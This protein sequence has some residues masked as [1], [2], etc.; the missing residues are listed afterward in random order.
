MRILLCQDQVVDQEAVDLEAAH[1][2]AVASA[3]VAASGEAH[4][5]ADLEDPEAL[6]DLAPVDLVPD[7]HFLAVG[8]SDPVTT[9]AEVALADFWE[10]FW[11][12]L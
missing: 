3:A 12:Q 5:A 7:L 1:A 2:A 6:T 9:A 8:T 4:A 11:R 10:L